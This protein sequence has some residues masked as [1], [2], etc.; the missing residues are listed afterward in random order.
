MKKNK[1]NLFQLLAMKYFE[2]IESYLKYK[3]LNSGIHL[4]NIKPSNNVLDLGFGDGKSLI[5]IRNK[6]NKKGHLYG[7]EKTMDRIQTGYN[8]LWA[9][10]H[11]NNNWL[12]P[13]DINNGID[14]IDNSFDKIFIYFTIETF[15]EMQIRFI[16]KEIYRILKKNGDIVFVYLRDD[17]NIADKKYYDYLKKIFNIISDC[18]PVILEDFMIGE[19]FE[20]KEIKKDNIFN[21]PVGFLKAKK[22]RV[23]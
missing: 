18:N 2:L 23:T 6:L 1:I 11:F 10:N 22:L 20:I 5:S 19:L 21:V 9:K 17:N 15:D 16:I 13:Q 7:I 14:F 8:L 12:Y 3:T 4:L